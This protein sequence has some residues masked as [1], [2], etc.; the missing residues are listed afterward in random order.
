MHHNRQCSLQAVKARQQ[1]AVEPVA[2]IMAI[3]TAVLAALEAEALPLE[4]LP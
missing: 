4:A 2:P 3:L 1:P